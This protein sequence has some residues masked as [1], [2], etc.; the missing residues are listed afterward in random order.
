MGKFDGVLLVSDFDNTLVDT[1]AAL[2]RGEMAHLTQRSREALEYY[3][4]EG[5]LFTVATGRALPG[6]IRFAPEVPMN[7][8]SVIC[9][10]A[11]LYDFSKGEYLDSVWLDS[12]ALGYAAEVLSRF[13]RVGLEAYH[14]SNT[15]YA[16]NVNEQVRLHR[17]VIHVDLKEVTD[18]SEVPLPLGKIIFEEKHEFLEPVQEWIRAQDWAKAYEV[19]FSSRTILE[20]TAGGANKGAMV[21]RL[22]EKLGI[23]RA[24][25]YCAGDEANDLSMLRAAAEGFVPSGSSEEVLRSGATV[26]A[27]RS[28]DPIVEIIG[29]LDR[30]YSV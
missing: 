24:H 6:F 15:V 21:L 5:G 19:F 1:A 20:L 27:D 3:I 2:Q 25:I 23:D 26:V 11:G 8:P 22:A 14:V 4:G 9:N 18:L 13:P 12:S 30:R 28:H 10:G 7:A 16:V 29:I 17:R